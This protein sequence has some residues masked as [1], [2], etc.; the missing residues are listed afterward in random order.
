MRVVVHDVA[1][2]PVEAV[3]VVDARQV[4]VHRAEVLEV[5]VLLVLRAVADQEVHAD[6]CPRPIIERIAA[7]LE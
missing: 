1:R 5:H 6:L 7:N 2:L 4:V 3:L